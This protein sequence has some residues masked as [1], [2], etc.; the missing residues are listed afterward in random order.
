[1]SLSTLARNE[2]AHILA[3]GT[4]A[5]SRGV[6]KDLRHPE[7]VQNKDHH[8]KD[9]RHG[10]H[11][12]EPEYKHRICAGRWMVQVVVGQSQT[13]VTECMN[14]QQA[15]QRTN[16]SVEQREVLSRRSPALVEGLGS[17]SLPNE[18][19]VA[20]LEH[21]EHDE[22]E[23]GRT[24]KSIEYIVYTLHCL[25]CQTRLEGKRSEEVSE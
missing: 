11:E 18:K 21:R 1:V 16:A 20:H 10:I 6:T 2:L 22:L 12:N 4:A 5:V 24:C 9:I 15:S 14:S 17:S 7:R 8:F 13:S 23:E 19:H 3:D 25:T